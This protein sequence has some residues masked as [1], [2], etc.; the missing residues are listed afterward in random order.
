M[1]VHAYYFLADHKFCLLE[2]MRVHGQENSRQALP[3]TLR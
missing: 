1:E 2:G 3:P